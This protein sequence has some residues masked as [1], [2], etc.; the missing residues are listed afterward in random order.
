MKTCTHI[1]SVQ[2]KHV[3]MHYVWEM[4]QFVDNDE[5]VM[6]LSALN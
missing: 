2:V 5:A 4:W 6:K 3:H 1:I